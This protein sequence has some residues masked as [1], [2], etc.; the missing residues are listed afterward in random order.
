MI[1]E[2]IAKHKLKEFKE[3]LWVHGLRSE[4]DDPAR[5]NEEWQEVVTKIILG[6]LEGII[7]D[8]GTNEAEIG[9]GISPSFYWFIAR[10]EEAYGGGIFF[11]FVDPET[12]KG[13][14]GGV[15][16]FD[17]GGLWKGYIKTDPPFDNDDERREFFSKNNTPLDSWSKNFRD[18][19]NENYSRFDD[20]VEGKAPITGIIEIRDDGF[21]KPRAWTWEG[22][23]VLS[24]VKG[25]AR[26]I[27]FLC[28]DEKRRRFDEWLANEKKIELKEKIFL[29]RWIKNNFSSAKG[30]ESP[31]YTVSEILKELGI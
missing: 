26:K 30:D 17:T 3:P 4:I 21:N 9:L 31:I 25:K 16:P 29:K 12:C 11:D 23:I 15:C 19:I 10:T 2:I 18:Y 28:S 8:A 7:S 20:Y 13:I 22:R 6:N 1:N 5:E 14:D 27:F 24:Q